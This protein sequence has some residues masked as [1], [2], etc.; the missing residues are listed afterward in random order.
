MS[1]ENVETVEL[2][3]AA[4]NR[5]D[6]EGLEELY[7]ADAVLQDLQNAPD[8]PVTVEGVQAIRQTLNLWAAAIDELRVDWAGGWA[9]RDQHQ[10]TVSV[11][12]QNEPESH[13]VVGRP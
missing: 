12:P 10:V 2:V 7:G 5:G 13:L 4:L 3:I 6:F 8:Q 11:Q 9:L 1:E